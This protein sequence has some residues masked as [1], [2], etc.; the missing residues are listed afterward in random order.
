MYFLSLSSTK[1]Q[2]NA[3]LQKKHGL[4]LES[5]ILPLLI[6]KICYMLDYNVH[7]IT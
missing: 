5:F 6:F 7:A 2:K 4:A 1:K 3:N